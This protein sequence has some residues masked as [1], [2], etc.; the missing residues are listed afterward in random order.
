MKQRN[1]PVPVLIVATLF[2]LSGVI[3]LIYHFNEL[4]ESA[5][6]LDE[7][8]AVLVLRLLAVVCG[9]LLFNG[10]HWAR[11]LAIAWLVCHVMLSA[12]HSM[13]AALT[14]L[15]LLILVAILLYLPASTA[16]FN[17]SIRP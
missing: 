12:L 3:G 8:V 13:P 5:V 1:R 17:R 4:L 7:S 11:W 6:P 10:V 2:F 15:V 16:Y 14:H 9:I